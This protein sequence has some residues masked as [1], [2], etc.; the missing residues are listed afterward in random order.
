MKNILPLEKR[1]T[2]MK[3]SVVSIL[4]E[5]PEIRKEEPKVPPAI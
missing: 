4:K 1:V 3:D 2:L 5:F